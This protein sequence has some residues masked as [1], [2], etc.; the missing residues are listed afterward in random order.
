MNE[1]E[2]YPE[3]LDTHSPVPLVLLYCA[4]CSI[5]YF[6]FTPLLLL[7]QLLQLV[8]EEYLVLE[9]QHSIEVLYCYLV[10]DVILIDNNGVSTVYRSCSD[11]T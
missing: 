11:C 1:N 8:L 2:Y 10:I 5:H 9:V 7:Q 4:R 3:L 6:L